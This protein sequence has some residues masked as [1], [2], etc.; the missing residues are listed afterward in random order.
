MFESFLP[1]A[2]FGPLCLL[3][4][5]VSSRVSLLYSE[6]WRRQPFNFFCNYETNR[7]DASES[8]VLYDLN[9]LIDLATEV[10]PDYYTVFCE[11]YADNPICGPDSEVEL[12]VKSQTLIM[13][14]R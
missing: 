2:I 5:K 10:L 1:W 9:E 8:L 14:S 12:L 11:L 7:Q 4:Y 13:S 3:G 6:N